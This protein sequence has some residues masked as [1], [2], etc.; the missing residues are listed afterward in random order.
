MASS[1]PAGSPS[2]GSQQAISGRVAAGRL[3]RVHHGVD[4]T[5][6]SHAN[7]AQAIHAVLADRPAA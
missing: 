4:A 2:S 7:R 5:A 3:H 1:R 6:R